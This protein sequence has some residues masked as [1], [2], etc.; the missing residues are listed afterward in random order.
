[1]VEN[2][3]QPETET[4]IAE[5]LKHSNKLRIVGTGH[6]WSPIC[7]STDTLLS[8]DRYNKVLSL[9][10]ENLQVTVQ[11]GI[12][13]WQ[14]NKY[15]DDNGL[16]LKNLGSISRQSVAGAIST[17]THGT[18][19]NFPI[20]AGQV[21][22]FKL[23][24]PDGTI[25][26]I[27]RANDEELFNLSVVNL[28]ALGIISEIT[29]N[30]VPAYCL[31]EQTYVA[32]LNQVID[33][34]D[35]IVNETDHFK[36]WWFPH[37]YRYTRTQ[38]PANDSLFR[39]WFM[40]EFLSVNV[41]RLL[42]KVGNINRNWRTNI[43][44]TLVKK[45]IHPIDRIEK[46]YKVFNVPEPPIHR[47]VEWAFDLKVAKELL[48]EYTGMINTSKHRINFIQEIRFTKADNYALSP[49]Y[50]RNTMWL[51][52]YNADNFGWYELMRDFEKLAITYN[53]R[54]HWGKEF[55]LSAKYLSKQY[56]MFEKFNTVRQQFDPHMKLMND[57]IARIFL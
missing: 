27:H 7:L 35:A 37:V 34:L 43:N 26:K 45:F 48:K 53:G 1:L 51:G 8:L 29:L 41:Y 30:V 2:Y 40:D 13:L 38:Q 54:P 21:E 44:R 28:G 6:S 14:L 32:D 5:A 4:E 39:Q 15:L 50:G 36:L 42:L 31:H 46:S 17:G 33:N 11:A 12:K 9:N 16:A 52:A 56:P 24:K 10:K 57:Y 23:I 18:G 19:I 3:F 25:L 22:E 55:T 49:C 47:E 20:L